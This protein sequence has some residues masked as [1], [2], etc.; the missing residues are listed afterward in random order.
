MN[1]SLGIAVATAGLLIMTVGV[2]GANVVFFRSLPL[3]VNRQLM[4]A[5]RNAVLK[6]VFW[7]VA[8]AAVAMSHASS[9]DGARML[10]APGG[11]EHP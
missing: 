2:V 9:T 6:F 11:S 7:L 3:M 8:W 10:H 4:R 1:S 5:A